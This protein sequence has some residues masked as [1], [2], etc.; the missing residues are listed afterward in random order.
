MVQ[1]LSIP[2]ANLKKKGGGVFSICLTLTLDFIR[3]FA[4]EKEENND[5]CKTTHS[6]QN[7]LKSFVRKK[8]N[9]HR[10]F[11]GLLDQEL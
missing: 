9:Q 1:Y 5:G 7:V 4:L 3:I 6:S 2:F 8:K 11:S 10:T